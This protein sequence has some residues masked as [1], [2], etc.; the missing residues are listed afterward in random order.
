M[1]REKFLT[2]YYGVRMLEIGGSGAVI[3]AIA[4]T[5]IAGFITDAQPVPLMRY[6]PLIGGLV[7]GLVSFFVI[8]VV[9]FKKIRE[10]REKIATL[11]KR[12]KMGFLQEII[13]SHIYP[14]QISAIAELKRMATSEAYQI[15][16]E[17]SKNEDSLIREEIK[18]ALKERVF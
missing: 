3:G 15:L 10:F 18:K 13:S 14:L 5:I 12:Q 8:L 9:D 7:G 1:K 16:K 2:L 11:N 6:S 17:A 4:F